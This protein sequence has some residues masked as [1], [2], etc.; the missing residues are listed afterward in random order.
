MVLL[1]AYTSGEVLVVTLADGHLPSGTC[2][3]ETGAART[4]YFP[5]YTKTLPTGGDCQLPDSPGSGP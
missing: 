3:T 2:D 5:L 1:P 4:M